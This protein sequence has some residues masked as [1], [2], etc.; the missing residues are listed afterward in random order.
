MEDSSDK[1]LN[2][3]MLNSDT[4]IDTPTSPNNEAMLEHFLKRHFYKILFTFVFILLL[5][6]IYINGMAI[7]NRNLFIGG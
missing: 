2:N 4:T 1:L 5:A 3:N 6:L 7:Y